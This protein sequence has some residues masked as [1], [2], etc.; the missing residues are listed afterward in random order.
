M[1]SFLD[2]CTTTR[3]YELNSTPQVAFQDNFAH[4]VTLLTMI[5][6]QRHVLLRS[7]FAQRHVFLMAIL[8]Q[9]HVLLCSFFGHRHILLLTIFARRLVTLRLIQRLIQRHKTP[10]LDSF[11]RWL[12][13]FAFN[14]TSSHVFCF[15]STFMFNFAHDFLCICHTLWMFSCCHLRWFCSDNATSLVILW[16]FVAVCHRHCCEV[17]EILSEFVTLVTV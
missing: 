15:K 1:T 4:W 13:R 17:T 9:R 16:Q 3:K 14:I 5:F 2:N 7:F 11:A 6:A 10:C 8:A 12:I